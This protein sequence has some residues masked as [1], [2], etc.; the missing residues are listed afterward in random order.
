[1]GIRGSP[2]STAIPP[3]SPTPFYFFPHWPYPTPEPQ[4][5]NHFHL[6][7][8]Q[9]IKSLENFIIFCKRD[10]T[11]KEEKEERQRGEEKAEGNDTQS[12]NPYQSLLN[13]L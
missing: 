7:N 2:P 13:Q 6:L 11:V 1:M 10:S 3:K 4:H 5:K 12:H 8:I 9:A